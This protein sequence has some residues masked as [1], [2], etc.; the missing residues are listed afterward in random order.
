MKVMGLDI[1]TTTVGF[2]VVESDDMSLVDIGH[3]SLKK[4]VGLYKKA[5]VVMQWLI[6]MTTKRPLEGTVWIEE[7]TKRFTPG[8]SSADTI[9]TLASFNAIISYGIYSQLAHGLAHVKPG[10]ARRTCGLVLTTRAKAGNRSQKEQSYDQLTSATGLLRNVQ[11][12]LTKTGKPR[13]ENMDQ[14][15]AYVIAY[16]GAKMAK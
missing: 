8:M 6:D 4:H 7:P 5:D 15:D 11:F 14:T 1:S 16:H 3:L 13:A 2:A 9:I 10:E 12:P